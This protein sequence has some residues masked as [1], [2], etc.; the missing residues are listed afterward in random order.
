VT[1]LIEEPEAHLHPQLQHTLVRYL[2]RQVQLRPELQ[3]ILSS[4]ATDIISSCDPTELVIVRRDTAGRRVSRAVGSIPFNGATEVLRKTRLHL[5]A[6]RS[7]ALFADRVLLVEGVTE[8][9]VLR[10]L[11]WAW[12]GG[13]ED[14]Q[15]FV[16]ALSIV[17]MGTKVGP[18]AVRL[19]ATRDHELCSRVAVLRDSDLDFGETPSPPSWAE[20]H[21]PAVLLVEH[22]HP[23]LEPQLTEGNEALIDAALT[24]IGLDVPDPVT[25][26]A[27][28][29]VFRSKHKDADGNTLSAGPG[30]RRKGEFAEAVAGR[31]RDA[32]YS[33]AMEVEVP[34]PVANAFEFLYSAT[35]TQ[36]DE[37]ENV[38]SPK[39][40]D[41]L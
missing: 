1:V 6:S 23:T 2:R 38:L 41:L 33:G 37:G 14:K 20:D 8:A 39:D 4:H 16:D 7:A 22:S 3:I 34:T 36:D 5:D 24:D 11:G 35:A 29:D 15:A 31:L 17:P 19:L 12:A 21:N 30:A 25:P 13:D 18:W 10:E 26:E 9:A 27:I 40:E 32:R 28:R